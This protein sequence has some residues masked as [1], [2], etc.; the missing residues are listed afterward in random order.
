MPLIATVTAIGVGAGV[1]VGFG[2]GAGVGF[3]VGAGVESGSGS[4][5]ILRDR[6]DRDIRHRADSRKETPGH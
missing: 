3:G 2:V 5:N 4:K 1:G 6:R